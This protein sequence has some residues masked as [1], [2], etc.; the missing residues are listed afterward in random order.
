MVA[1]NFKADYVLDNNVQVQCCLH[2]NAWG[3]L[4]GTGGAGEA[5]G[6]SGAGGGVLD[7]SN[8]GFCCQMPLPLLIAMLSLVCIMSTCVRNACHWFG[9]GNSLI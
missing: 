7:L 4:H 3:P 2:S 5:G 8:P 1:C 6:A 9:T